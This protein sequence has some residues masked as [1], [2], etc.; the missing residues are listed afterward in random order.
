MPKINIVEVAKAGGWLARNIP[1]IIKWFKFLKAK[2]KEAKLVVLVA[3]ASSTLACGLI[4]WS[5]LPNIPLPPVRV[6]STPTVQP[7]VEPTQVPT[8]TASPQPGFT[9]TPT[10][11]PIPEPT[12]PPSCLAKPS[13]EPV[14]IKQTPRCSRGFEPLAFQDDP[15]LCA[16]KAG[17]GNERTS[18]RL[19]Y[20]LYNQGMKL[21]MVGNKLLQFNEGRGYTD[22]L[23]RYYPDG[24]NLYQHP[25]GYEAPWT[26]GGYKVPEFCAEATPTPLPIPGVPT[27]TPFYPPMQPKDFKL[28]FVNGCQELH[29][30]KEQN[31]QICGECDSTYRFIG[32]LKSGERYGNTC[33]KDHWICAKYN[34]PNISPEEQEQHRKTYELCAGREWDDPVKGSV[35]RVEGAN[36][37]TQDDEN[38]YKHWVCVNPGVELRIQACAPANPMTED[39]LAIP[40]NGDGCGANKLVKYE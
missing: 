40:V 17:E 18:W 2:K 10:N 16:V 39:G 21:V 38:P 30:R 11:T 15:T 7:T 31:G 25:E 23:G 3:L 29:Y 12:E 24:V 14:S 5:N 6:T 34:C 9:P 26:W 32:T 35:L 37:S 20:G 28:N 1:T 27:P 4:D 36:S 19:G 22:A 13:A 8:A 33:N